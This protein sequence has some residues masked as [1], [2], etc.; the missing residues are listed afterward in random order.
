MKKTLWLALVLCLVTGFAFAQVDDRVNEGNQ[1]YFKEISRLAFDDYGDVEFWA[2]Q[3][4]LIAFRSA[5]HLTSSAISINLDREHGSLCAAKVKQVV[6]LNRTMAEK[7][8]A[9]D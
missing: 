2:K 5:V 3:A 9:F 8:K 1:V 4:K 6:A 7:A